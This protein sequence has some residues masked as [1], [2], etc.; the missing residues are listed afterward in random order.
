MGEPNVDCQLS[1][2]LEEALIQ[3]F[4]RN[5]VPLIPV[6]IAFPNLFSQS[7]CFRAAVL[8]LAS[9]N[10]KLSQTL[11]LD[12]KVLRRVYDD[13]SVWSYYDTAV[14]GLQQHL[15][16]VERH[17]GE[18]LAGAALLLAYHEFEAGTALG[19]RN[20][21][22]G[23]DAIAS[24][25]D[26]AASST[27][28]LFKA[29]RMLR[30]D[31]QLMMAP[32][33]RTCNV[34]DNYDV[35]SLLD[36]QLA[37]RDIL[38][39]LHRLQT[40][41][42][43]ESSFCQDA[44]AD[45]ASASEK[46]ARWLSSILDRECDRRI[47]RQ[48]D[49][50]RESLTPESILQQCDVLS[51]RLDTWHKSLCAHDM[52]VANLGTDRDFVSGPTFE[53]LVT[54]RFADDRKAVEYMMYLVCRITCNYLRSLFDASFSAAA[55]EAWAK[56][57]LGIA[58]GMNVQRQQFTVLRVDSLLQMTAA[59][60]DG[61]NFATTVLDYLVPK[62]IASGLSGPDIVA[63]ASM[64]SLFELDLR[65]KRKGRA[66]RATVEGIE[67][68]SEMWQLVNRHPVAVFGDCYG[69]GHF[70]D[71]HVIECLS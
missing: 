40:R 49:F 38:L 27:P 20:H 26:F 28:D 16:H 34:V 63:W 11:P 46:A 68:H 32:N 56:V 33:R 67:E 8:A 23:L 69:K 31:V 48:R 45:G 35:S 24:K 12:A 44:G 47:I 60:C 4:D 22:T 6:T 66:I 7:S 13:R 70:R 15:Q 5:V 39:R 2:P 3:H 36:P 1:M 57:I 43:M 71:C 29:W 53:T 18:E 10:L 42:A 25:L 58:C 55:S 30:C 21:A 65:E 50:H 59:V 37:I 61:T 64:K 41:H 19:I 52:P 54:Y 9:S 62:V 51:R 14:K 17:R